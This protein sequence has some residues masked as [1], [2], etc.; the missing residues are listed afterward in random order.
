MAQKYEAI[1]TL[2]P[3]AARTTTE[4]GADKGFPPEDGIFV[5]DITAVSGTPTLDVTIEEKDEVSGK[6]F[7]IDTFPQQTGVVSIRRAL[8]GPIGGTIRARA[9]IAGTTPSLTFTVSAYG[10]NQ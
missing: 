2:L 10:K 7:V 3:S 5:L 9:V 8:P 6:Y 1:V 4:N